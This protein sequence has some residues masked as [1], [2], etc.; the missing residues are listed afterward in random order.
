MLILIEHTIDL[1][2]VLM[3][4]KTL[5]LEFKDELV[6]HHIFF[7]NRFWYFFQCVDTLSFDINSFMDRPEFSTP[8]PAIDN[9]IFNAGI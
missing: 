2:N 8:K 4:Q 5:D 3:F 9:K 7:E 1:H 6:N